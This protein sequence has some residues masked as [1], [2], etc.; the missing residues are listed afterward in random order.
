MT[1]FVNILDGI[2][3]KIAALL[4]LAGHDLTEAEQWAV[5]TLAPSIHALAKLAESKGIAIAE[6]AALAAISAASAGLTGGASAAGQAAIAAA[7][8]II[9]TEAPDA[10]HALSTAAVTAAQTALADVAAKIP[11]PAVN[12]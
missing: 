4:G 9:I 7:K 3:H 12:E 2:K 10:I 1:G 6:E 5:K 8:A 11:A